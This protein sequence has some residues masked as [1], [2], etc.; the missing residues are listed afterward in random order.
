M[1]APTIAEVLREAGYQT[2]MSGKWHLSRT[3]VLPDKEEQL[4]WLAHQ[5]DSG[6]FAPLETYPCNRGFDDHWGVI[7]GV[8]NYFDPF[9]LVHNEEAVRDI[10]DNFYMT[11]FVTDKSVE[12]TDKFSRKKQPLILYVAHTAPHWP[13]H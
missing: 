2:G 7:W 1:D 11:D 12:L 8:V 3:K 6:F 4:K 10:P 5:T 9:S 13:L